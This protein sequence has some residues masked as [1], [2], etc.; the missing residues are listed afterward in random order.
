MNEATTA[1]VK[2]KNSIDN[3]NNNNCSHALILILSLI[4]NY[5]NEKKNYLHLVMILK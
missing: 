4:H 3:N 5:I 2:R 1:T